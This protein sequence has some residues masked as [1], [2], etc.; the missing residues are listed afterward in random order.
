MAKRM[1]G[2]KRVIGT[3]IVSLPAIGNVLMIALLFLLI[4]SIL[5]VQLFRGQ[6]YYCHGKEEDRY[7]R[8]ISACTG[9]YLNHD[10]LNQTRSWTNPP[11][12]LIMC[13]MLW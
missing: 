1:E 8:S 4:F 12:I 10:G 6:L 7:L 13:S 2:I 11:P 5:G 9:S 3:I